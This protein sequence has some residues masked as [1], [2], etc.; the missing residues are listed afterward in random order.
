MRRT[1]TNVTLLSSLAVLTTCDVPT[2]PPDDVRP[3][4]S[5]VASQ[6]GRLL[7]LNDEWARIARTSV[8]GFA[9]MHRQPDGTVAVL[10][11]DV[12]RR[13]EAEAYVAEEFDR[14][15][16]IPAV[17]VTPAQYDFDQLN[18]W[19]LALD[20][21]FQRSRDIA[22]LDIDEV[23]NRLAVGVL[24]SDAVSFVRLNANDLGI[25]PQA[26]DVRIGGG[27]INQSAVQHTLQE[28]ARPVDGGYEVGN[29]A[30]P[31]ECTFS[32]NL[33]IDGEPFFVTASHCTGT[34]F[35]LDQSRKSSRIM[36]PRSAPS[37]RTSYQFLAST[38]RAG[39]P[40]SVHQDVSLPTRRFL[41]FTT[42]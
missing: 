6:S 39:I 10:L 28:R 35:E 8:P 4:Q 38:F 7:N 31:G 30:R 2:S 29:T 23:N 1:V 22:S 33:I 16:Q 37:G 42:L 21:L 14:S 41:S 19:F 13:A 5:V 34:P 15:A 20:L 18:Q 32:W 24:N 12:S 17:D 27:T 3:L 36:Q 9:G 11:T 25:P 40:G 26:L